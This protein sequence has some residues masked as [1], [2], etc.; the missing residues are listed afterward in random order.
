MKIKRLLT[1]L[2]AVV[3]MLG[4]CACGIGN[5]EESASV[6]ARKAEYQPG[7]YVTLGTYPQTESGNDSTPIE[8]LVLES[9]GKTA[10]LISRYAL[11]C[12]PYSTECISITWE[13]CTLRSWL[14][15]EFYNRAFSAKEKERILVSDVSA[16]KNPAY[17]RRNPGNAT[18]D[19]IFLLSVAEANKYFASDEARM[20]AVTD[21]AIEQV[22]YYM[23]DDIDDDTVAEIENDYE[24]DGRIAWAW[25]LRTPGDRSSGAA[26][27]NEGGSIYDYGYYAGDSNLAVRPCVRVRLF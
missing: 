20:C 17:D 19:S 5:G 6:E 18:K 26:R 21:Y 2:L 13:K 8:W 7:S 3:L 14:N 27:V 9:D 22:V 12:Q 4:I 1:L 11:D 16:D 24:V 15:N 23:D 10:L 25:W